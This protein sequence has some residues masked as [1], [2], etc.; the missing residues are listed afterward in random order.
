MDDIGGIGTIHSIGDSAVQRALT[1]FIDRE[2]RAGAVETNERKAW[3]QYACAALSALIASA[4]HQGENLEEGAGEY[5]DEMLKLE[6]E[7][8]SKETP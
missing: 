4:R 1:L 3:R 5:A 2:E 7:R 6:R 8:F